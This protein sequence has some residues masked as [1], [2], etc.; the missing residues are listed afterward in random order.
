[1]ISGFEVTVLV[2]RTWTLESDR[3]GSNAR[4]GSFYM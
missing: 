1:M 2:E 4:L 3:P